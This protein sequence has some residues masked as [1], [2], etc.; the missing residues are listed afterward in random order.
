MSGLFLCVLGVFGLIFIVCGALAV[1][2]SGARADRARRRLEARRRHPARGSTDAA[3]DTT[4]LG[5]VADE[6]QG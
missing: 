1:G 4:L 5:S 6:R 3:A 2:I